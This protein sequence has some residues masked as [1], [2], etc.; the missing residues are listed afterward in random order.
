MNKLSCLGLAA[1]LLATS[2]IPASAQDEAKPSPTN[3]PADATAG[4]PK[5]FA[6]GDWSLTADTISPG[7]SHD[8]KD[9]VLSA[10]GSPLTIKHLD[11]NKNP[12]LVATGG[13]VEFNHQTQTM[14]L[15]GRPT[16]KQGFSKMIATDDST[17]IQITFGK[18]FNFS[19]KGPHRI[20][21]SP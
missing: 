13:K 2:P 6:F 19:I 5:T 15:S 20:E 8:G 18:D 9:I 17:T 1:L 21:L 16:I 3:E 10:S 4:S 7:L 14:V 12:D 11:E